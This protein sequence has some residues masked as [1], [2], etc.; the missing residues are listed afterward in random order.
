MYDV[1]HNTIS[2]TSAMEQLLVLDD[3][4]VSDWLVY[5]YPFPKC[6]CVSVFPLTASR[7]YARLMSLGLSK[8]RN[9]PA[10]AP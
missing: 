6:V 3:D 5:N 2:T 8:Q 4:L 9:L 1:Q 7:T 10:C